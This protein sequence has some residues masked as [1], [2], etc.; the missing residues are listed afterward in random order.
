M[1]SFLRLQEPLGRV[2]PISSNQDLDHAGNNPAMAGKTAPAILDPGGRA[3]ANGLVYTTVGE[4]VADRVGPAQ[5][6]DS[7]V[8]I[9]RPACL[10]MFDR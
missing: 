9:A 7:R 2:A 5:A 10:S 8:S 6:G 4:P 1:G 3:V